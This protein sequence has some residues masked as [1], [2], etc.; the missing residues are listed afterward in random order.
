MARRYRRPS[1]KYKWSIERTALRILAGPPGTTNHT[2]IIPP[3]NA[4]GMRCIKHVSVKCTTQL[5]QIGIIGDPINIEENLVI[6]W[7]IVYVPEGYGP[8]DLILPDYTDATAVNRSTDF[9]YAN[10]FVMAAGVQSMTNPTFTAKSYLS[11]NLNSGDGIAFICGAVLNREDQAS[12]GIQVPMNALV[13][14]ATCFK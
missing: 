4:E 11:R 7:A 5:S 3:S 12:T 9:Y 1:K 6:Y 2:V 10:Q 14:Y 13:T 8:Q